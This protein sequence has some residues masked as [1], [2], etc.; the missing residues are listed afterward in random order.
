MLVSLERNIPRLDH[1]DYLV[2]DNVVLE[3][4][5]GQRVKR[6]EHASAAAARQALDRTLAR[7]LKGNWRETRR[8]DPGIGTASVHAFYDHVGTAPKSV[9]ETE[10]AVSARFRY[11]R[12]P[13]PP[14]S[15]L[16]GNAAFCQPE[17]DD[18]W[19]AHG[20]MTIEV[21]AAPDDPGPLQVFW[22]TYFPPLRH[23]ARWT[24]I[25]RR[26]GQR[27][28]VLTI[29]GDRTPS[30]DQSQTFTGTVLDLE[31]MTVTTYDRGEASGADGAFARFPD[32]VRGAWET[33]DF[34]LR[35]LRTWDRQES[36]WGAEL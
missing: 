11:D 27:I 31:T 29:V 17:L 32:E 9:L 25:L 26:L 36:P 6:K 28:A 8:V 33:G 15:E 16:G 1:V 24:E 30:A 4:G 20:G 12:R 23:Q 5:Y 3:I 21:L 18:Y 14:E 19:R 10:G 13:G 2:R 34:L 22:S 35:T 7:K